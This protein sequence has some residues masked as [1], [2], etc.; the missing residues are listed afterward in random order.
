MTRKPSIIIVG[1]ISVVALT[2]WFFHN[3]RSRAIDA[4]ALSTETPTSVRSEPLSPEL[5]TLEGTYVCLPLLAQG[6]NSADCAFGI[7][8]DDG[9]FYAVNFGARAGSMADF[10]A[11]AHIK[12]KG[13]LI[14]RDNLNPNS[15]E[16]FDM[17]GLFTVIEKL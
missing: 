1:L 9:I 5:I 6:A 7:E 10:L 12:A 17:H 3:V 2:F 13:T 8:S 15:W 11:G 14:L 4:P 16:K